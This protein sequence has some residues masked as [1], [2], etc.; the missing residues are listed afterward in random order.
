[1]MR[2]WLDRKAL[3]KGAHSTLSY[4]QRSMFKLSESFVEGYKSEVPP[5]GYN[6]LGELVYKRTYSRPFDNGESEQWYQTCERV[7][8]RLSH[9]CMRC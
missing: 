8:Y 5:F 4:Q 9:I 7:G 3:F 1:M 6:G 2:L